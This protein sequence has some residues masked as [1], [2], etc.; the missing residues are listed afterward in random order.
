MD[1]KMEDWTDAERENFEA[2]LNDCDTLQ[3]CGAMIG[4]AMRLEAVIVIGVANGIP[5]V[6][7]AGKEPLSPKSEA[8]MVKFQTTLAALVKETFGSALEIDQRGTGR[9][10]G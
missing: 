8:L 7:A 6:A 3:Q 9:R 5:V 10:V 1:K 4:K 2:M